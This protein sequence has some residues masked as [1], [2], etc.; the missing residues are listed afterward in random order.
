MSASTLQRYYFTA[1]T[2][3]IGLLAFFIFRPF[4]GAIVL[5]ATF[6]VIFY[7]LHRLVL[8]GTNNR[9][10]TAAAA[11]TTL[12]LLIV[13]VP[14]I[15]FGIQI[16]R[17]A[18]AL[19]FFATNPNYDISN[20][21]SQLIEEQVRLFLPNFSLDLKLYAAQAS[22]WLL[23][24]IGPAFSSATRIAINLLLS[25]FI[26]FYLFRDGAALIAKLIKLSPLPDI[27][28]H[29]II[30]RLKSATNSVIRGSLVIALIQGAL[31]GLGFALF[32]VPNAA[33]WGSVTVLAALV[34]NVGTG[35][36]ITP[37]I[38][39]LFLTNQ[40]I[41]AIGLLTWGI[42]AVGLVDNVLGP[43]LINRGLR[44]HPLIV[45]LAV[46]GGLQLFGPIGYILG[47]LI[48]SLLFTLIDI[49]PRLLAA[50]STE[51]GSPGRAAA[52]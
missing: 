20:V 2:A 29:Q 5:A 6:A 51:R 27:H 30:K 47:P 1:V 37:A 14:L 34:P 15:A 8:H 4:T 13:F 7:P 35:L 22:Q 25:M 52:K 10:N 28:D 31:T 50:R 12:V 16:I 32:G 36:I 11:T 9:P 24:H 18:Q 21:L 48:I 42:T 17:E 44:L 19:Y 23:Q 39:Y 40:L 38:I 3:V 41:Q 43:A 26:L 45:L 49:Y 46:I 33:L